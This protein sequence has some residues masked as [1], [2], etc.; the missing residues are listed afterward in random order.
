MLA[1]RFVDD[2][3]KQKRYMRNLTSQSYY[4]QKV[5]ILLQISKII[6]LK[7]SCY[8]L[9]QFQNVFFQNVLKTKSS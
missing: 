2:G 1:R 4:T 7:N 5:A 9:Y 8:K 6:K 3:L